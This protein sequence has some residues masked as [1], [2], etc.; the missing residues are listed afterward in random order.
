MTKNL[1]DDFFEALAAITNAH[2]N[3]SRKNAD[4]V[5]WFKEHFPEKGTG[6][7]VNEL[8]QVGNRVIEQ[9]KHKRSHVVFITKDEKTEASLILKAKSNAYPALKSLLFVHFD[10]EKKSFSPTHLILFGASVV[11][12]FFNTTFEG[13]S[14]ETL[15]VKISGAPEWDKLDLP[16]SPCD[17]VGISKSCEQALSALKAGKHLIL[18]GPPGTGKTSL[19]ECICYLLNVSKD[20]VTAT[21][22]WTTFDTIGGYLPSPNDSSALDFFPALILKAIEQK[23]WL[24]IDEINR[25]DIDKA[26]GELF[27]LLSGNDVKLPYFK[28]SDGGEPKDIILKHSEGNDYPDAITYTV[29]KDWR[30][31]GTMNTFDKAALFQ[32]SYAF[33]RRFAF[34]DVPIPSQEDF[35][36][37]LTNCI[38]STTIPDGLR[39]EITKAL[40]AI[41]APTPGSGLDEFGLCVGPAIPIDAVKYIE[42]RLQGKDNPEGALN[43]AL[44]EA[45]EMYL[46]P[47]FEGKDKEHEGILN[48]IQTILGLGEDQLSQTQRS[49]AT[50]TGVTNDLFIQQ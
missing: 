47:Q 28:R 15:E 17:M 38:V 46:Y 43:D 30:I 4:L 24:I 49:L 6:S 9:F 22:E 39:D 33:M 50:W 13:I 35:T 1:V 32:L 25:A 37:I 36:T 14:I 21:A 10:E 11:G 48:T 23:K 8:K 42:Q 12:D 45:L 44:L 27:T 34:I 26:F 18:V 5:A 7:I 20:T 19:A 40:T 31:L 41:F 16:E 3:N 29:D 2:P